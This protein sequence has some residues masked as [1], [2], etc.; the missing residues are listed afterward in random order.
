MKLIYALITL[1]MLLVSVEGFSQSTG[2]AK[3]D[4]TLLVENVF[5]LSE[6]MLLRSVTPNF[7]RRQ[8]VQWFFD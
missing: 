1:V 7:V 6:V 5:H 4:V 2:M 8:D 3:D